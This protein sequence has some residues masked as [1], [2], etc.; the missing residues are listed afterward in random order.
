M[1]ANEYKQKIN[2]KYRNKE[3]KKKKTQIIEVRKKKSRKVSSYDSLRI[4][5][6]TPHHTFRSK[7]KKQQHLHTYSTHQIQIHWYNIDRFEKRRKKTEWFSFKTKIKCELFIYLFIEL[8]EN[9]NYLVKRR[10][11]LSMHLYIFMI[12]PVFEYFFFKFLVRV[13]VT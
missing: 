4:Y 9:E 3:P 10:V 8:Y 11:H 7:L 13:W 12:W 5:K 6:M 2:I 1:E